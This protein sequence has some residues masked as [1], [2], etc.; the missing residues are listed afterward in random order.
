M[1]RPSA[2]RM[3]DMASRVSPWAGKARSGQAGPGKK[4][5][6]PASG[7]GA[8]G[9]PSPG[10]GPCVRLP[11][12]ARRGRALSRLLAA[13]AV[14]SLLAAVAGCGSKKPSPPPGGWGS[15]PPTQR[16]YTIKGK[17]YQPI[18]SADGYFEEGVASWYGEDFHGNPTSCGEIYDMHK[19]TAAHKI[20]PMHTRLK[21]TNLENGKSVE[22]RVN[23][24]GPFVAGR[25]IDMSYAGAKAL[26]MHVKGTTRVRL[27]SV[28]SIPGAASARQLPGPF[29]VQI[30]AF[31]H[32]GNA[33][34]LLA[35][36]RRAGYP[37]SRIHFKEVG[38]ER[39]YRVH[40]GTFATLDEAEAG[41]AKLAR[42]YRGAFVIAE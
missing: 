3:D 24:R 21:V 17:T 35:G 37:G 9:G 32:Q 2:T 7:P 40:A 28:G 30:G 26:D 29:Y 6:P 18:P 16:P 41:R 36:I 1:V 25:V 5:P 38:G 14:V 34:R 13:I 22:V 33:E 31:V 19:L 4:T 11:G 42:D 10:P 8:F 15:V 12:P 27:E 39:F 23:D 20:L